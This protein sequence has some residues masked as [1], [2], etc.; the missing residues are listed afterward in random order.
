MEQQHIAFPP[1]P[2]DT[3]C[4]T[5]RLTREDKTVR[6]ELHVLQQP[7]RARACGS[8]QKC[9]YIPCLICLSC[10]DQ[11]Q[12]TADRRPVDPPPIVQLKVLEVKPD[13]VVEDITFSMNSN[14]FLFATLEPARKLA[15]P[16]GMPDPNKPTVL[17]GTPVAGMVYLDRPAPAGYFIFPDLSVR[18]EGHF[19]LSFNLYEDLKRTED[20]DKLEDSRAVSSSN[21]HVTH[22][23]EVKSAPLQV[24]SAKNFPGLLGGTALS[25]VVADQGC[26]VRIRRDVKTRRLNTTT[27]GKECD[28]Y[29]DEPANQRAKMAR[30]SEAPYAYA[31]ASLGTSPP[32]TGPVVRPSSPA[33]QAT[34]PLAL[35]SPADNLSKIW[36]CH[37]INSRNIMALHRTL[38]KAEPSKLQ[39]KLHPLAINS[40][41]LHACM[42]QQ[43]QHQQ[44]QPIPPPA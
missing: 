43:Y 32:S 39:P 23:L 13:D 27:C 19:R 15:H 24:F 26:R 31:P 41:S 8:G 2:N 25:R 36:P 29:E 21:T 12:A 14:Y 16:R 10:T 28:E 30:E 6:Y 3:K 18:R 37:T 20:Y 11:A 42:Q 17:T 1:V 4:L 5:T 44:Q 33:M 35:L 22:R 7:V 40:R 9:S 34:K 38:S